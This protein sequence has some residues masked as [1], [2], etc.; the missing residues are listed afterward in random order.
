[1]VCS[2]S[3]L[4]PQEIQTKMLS[5]GHHSK[6]FTISDAISSLN[7]AEGSAGVCNHVFVSSF[8]E[9]GQDS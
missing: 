9:L 8:V 1:M 7:L 4:S 2:Q 3:K 5:E 6:Q